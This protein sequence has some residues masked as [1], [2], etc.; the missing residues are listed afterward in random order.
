VAKGVANACIVLIYNKVQ[1]PAKPSTPVRFRPSLQTL[2]DI[3]SLLPIPAVQR[4]GNGVAATGASNR[5]AVPA[6]DSPLT[7]GLWVATEAAARR[8]RRTYLFLPFL[9]R[10]PDPIA[11]MRPSQ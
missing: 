9:D 7:G 8:T 11:E 6:G 5:S 10:C 4:R 3:V 1:R 2:Y